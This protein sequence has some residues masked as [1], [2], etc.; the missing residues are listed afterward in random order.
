MEPITDHGRVL[1][2]RCLQC[3]PLEVATS[4]TVLP[5]VSRP[6]TT[7]EVEMLNGS[8]RQIGNGGDSSFG[9]ARS[10][11]NASA[12]MSHN[13]GSNN[14]VSRSARNNVSASSHLAS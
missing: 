2:G 14:N 3:K 1:N 6:A 11:N 4:Q 12:R 5:A 13:N 8:N 7:N 9:S 10:F